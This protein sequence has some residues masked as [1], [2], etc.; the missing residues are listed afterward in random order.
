[1]KLRISNCKSCHLKICWFEVDGQYSAY[2][3]NLRGG[4]PIPTELHYRSCPAKVRQREQSKCP[5]C[6]ISHADN[7]EKILD[8]DTIP[9]FCRIHKSSMKVIVGGQEIDLSDDFLHKTKK[10][11]IRTKLVIARKRAE[12]EKEGLLF[13]MDKFT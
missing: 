3:F 4:E 2:N 13:S 9:D 1:M 10:K 11:L 5:A 6:Q 8:I 12:L 7:I